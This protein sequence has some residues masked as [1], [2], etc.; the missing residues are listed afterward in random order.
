MGCGQARPRRLTIFTEVDL[1]AGNV[2]KA[3][4]IRDADFSILVEVELRLRARPPKRGADK[5]VGHSGYGS[6]TTVKLR[7]VSV[8]PDTEASFPWKSMVKPL[9]YASGALA[10]PAVNGRTAPQD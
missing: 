5:S 3:V 4:N 7:S 2:M 10:T 8:S 9:L 6:L 1:N